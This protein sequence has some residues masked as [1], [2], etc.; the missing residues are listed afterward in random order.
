MSSV[1]LTEQEPD[2]YQAREPIHPKSIKGRFR[3]FKTTVMVL[4]YAIF[5]LLPWLRWARPVGPEQAVLFDIPG[6]RF[7]IFDL[8]IH[9][10]D[11]FLLAGFLILAAWLLF[12]VTGLVGRAFCGYFCF[13]TLWTDL[14]MKV[15]YWVQG[16]RNKR[17]KLEKQPW[18]VEKISK[19]GLTL[20]IWTVIAF[21]TGFTF[22]AYWANAPHLFSAFFLGHAVSAAYITTGILTAT[23]L[24]AAG[25]A[26]EQVCIYMCPYARFQ[27]VMFDKET[28]LV[29]Y[30]AQRGEGVSGR[31]PL[32]KGLMA[33]EERHAAGVG[34]C[35]DCGL[36][37]QV[38]PTGID[39]RDGLQLACISCGLC[40]DAC[41][42]IMTKRGWPD[43]LIRYASELEIETGK[44]P[45]LLK[46]RTVGYGIATILVTSL[47]VYGVLSIKPA[48]FSVRQIRQPLFVMMSDGSI[49]NNYEVKINNK[50]QAP[51]DLHLE[52]KGLPGAKVSIGGNFTDLHIPADETR[53][54]RVH[55]RAPQTKGDQRHKI[56]FTLIDEHGLI[57]PIT[58]S[59]SFNYK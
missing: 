23:T 37:V 44:K 8:V 46:F 55:V 14:F 7:Y 49:Q 9:P 26:R 15:E 18:N 48:D 50:Q 54:Y 1:D 35:I 11:I 47:L 39:I 16:D 38:C 28:L 17:Q 45:S 2:Y 32:Q 56:Q 42:E 22:T 27:A 41:N 13:Q 5:F 51:L 30:D 52:V 10:Q 34:D 59:T 3:L 36:C 25:F 12:F 57:P 58:Q 20:L 6:R 40:I 33:L 21:W 31:K 24:V 19:K 4:A 53:N 43:G 29:S